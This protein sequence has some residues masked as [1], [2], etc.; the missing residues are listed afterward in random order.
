VFLLIVIATNLLVDT[1][2][3]LLDPRRTA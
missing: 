2:C 3:G 1:I